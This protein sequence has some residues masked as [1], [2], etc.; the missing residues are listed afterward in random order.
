MKSE[1][2]S[3]RVSTDIKTN[4]E[5]EARRRGMSLAAVLDL[6]AEEWLKRA[7][8]GMTMRSSSSFERLG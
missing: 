6:A 5:R 7:Q 2:Y 4:L 8:P 1:I 3:W